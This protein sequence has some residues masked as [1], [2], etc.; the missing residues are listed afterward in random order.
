[1]LCLLQEQLIKKTLKT[2]QSISPVLWIPTWSKIQ[3]W[4]L[5]GGQHCWH[6]GI[7]RI[8][9]NNLG[10]Q[11]ITFAKP[12]TFNITT[13]N[14]RGP[15][16]VAKCNSRLCILSNWKIRP[17]RLAEDYILKSRNHTRCSTFSYYKCCVPTKIKQIIAST[18]QCPAMYLRHTTADVPII[19]SASHWYC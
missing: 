1:M 11:C 8:P 2:V 14:S 5:N 10:A 3:V 9:T 17:W 13:R 19:E 6:L 4:L 7:G 15:N 18:L 16:S 12:P